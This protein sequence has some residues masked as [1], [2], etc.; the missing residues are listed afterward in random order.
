MINRQ[1]SP[2]RLLTKVELARIINVDCHTIER[3]VAA[4]LIPKIKINRTVRFDYSEVK[5]AL[6]QPSISCARER[7]NRGNRQI[8][9]SP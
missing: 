6:S 5:K 1:P 7:L 4:G 8:G 9:R 3:W 2:D